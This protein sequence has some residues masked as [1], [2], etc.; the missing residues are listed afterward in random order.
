MVFA[1]INIRAV[2]VAKNGRYP[3]G[4]G[5]RIAVMQARRGFVDKKSV[6]KDYDP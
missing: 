5:L 1:G 4:M 3:Q 6:W 2:W